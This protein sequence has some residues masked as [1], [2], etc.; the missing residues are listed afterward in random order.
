ME[1]VKYLTEP[2]VVAFRWLDKTDLVYNPERAS[3][4]TYYPDQDLWT[5]GPVV[6]EDTHHAT[7]LG[8]TPIQHRFLHELCHHLVARAL[9]YPRG[10]PI[11]WASANRQEMPPEAADLEWLYTA[12]GYWAYG[13]GMR[14]VRDYGALMDLSKRGVDL[15]RLGWQI[16]W[17]VDAMELGPMLVE[18]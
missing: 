11:L 1:S 13:V 3:V 9:S 15:S 17:G 12:A 5:G 14:D 2:G 10:C 6:T 18:L 7:R 4:T 16:R 8:I